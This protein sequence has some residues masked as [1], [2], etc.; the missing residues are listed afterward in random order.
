MKL[1]LR[2]VIV[3]GFSQQEKPVVAK[4]EHELVVKVTG[5][6][7]YSFILFFILLFFDLLPTL[8]TTTLQLRFPTA[9]Q[10]NVFFLNLFLVSLRFS[11]PEFCHLCSWLSWIFTCS[12]PMLCCWAKPRPLATGHDTA[13]NRNRR[14]LCSDICRIDT[15]SLWCVRTC[16]NACYVKRIAVMITC[17]SQKRCEWPL[18]A[19]WLWWLAKISKNFPRTRIAWL[20]PLIS[21]GLFVSFVLGK[22]SDFTS[23]TCRNIGI[24]LAESFCGL[25]IPSSQLSGNFVFS[26]AVFH[27]ST[28]SVV[29]LPSVLQHG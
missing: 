7:R 28:F 1:K 27:P 24:L 29:I 5:C 25:L 3:T 26:L 18:V 15:Q 17:V 6:W 14:N 13:I 20:A 9:I 12:W 8:S 19:N 23:E 11:V 22:S 2:S 16:V 4:S 21:G 10:L